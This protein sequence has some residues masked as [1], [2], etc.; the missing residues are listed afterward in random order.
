M[1]TTRATAKPAGKLPPIIQRR[2]HSLAAR[3]LH[4]SWLEGALWLVAAGCA[5]VLVQAT[6]DWLLDLSRGT[7]ALL[8]LGDLAIFGWF[9]FHYGIQ[10]WRKRLTPE[11]AAL[12][13]EKHWPALRTSLISAVQLARRP[14]GSPFLVDTLISQV[15][16][17][18]E[19]LDFRVVVGTGHLRKLL[20]AAVALLLVT[21]ALAW[22]EGPKSAILWQRLWLKNVPLPTQTIV[23][24]VSGNF[25]IQPGQTIELAANVQG[26]VPRSGRVEITYAGQPVQT[27]GITAKPG[28]PDLFTLMLPNV[29]QPL[30]YRFY[31]NDGRSPEFKVAIVHGPVLE[32]VT[33]EQLY[34]AYTALAKTQHAAGNLTLLA[35]S[36][37][38]VEGRA[39]QPLK[40]ARLQLSGL[41]QSVEM[42]VGADRKTV[43]AE[44][45]I[46]AEKLEGFS[47]VLQNTDGT[48]SQENTVYRVEI[49]PDKPPEITFAADQPELASFITTAHPR[50]RFEVRDD[51]QVKQVFLCCG[52]EGEKPDSPMLSKLK[53]IPLEV[54]KPAGALTYDYLWEKATDSGL[55][56]ESATINYWI[57]AIDNN[58]VTGPGI[59]RTPVHQWQVISIEAKRQELAEKLRKHGEAIDELSKRQEELRGNVGDLIKQD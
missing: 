48:E 1:K 38:H 43:S 37:L 27:I 3:V 17:R 2:L 40:A 49:I 10:P 24:P 12:R 11:L 16:K 51:F 59:G 7:R 42:K 32:A 29:Q 57:E 14:D 31:L 26:V 35:G 30:M 5:L 23:I 33:F 46:P 53:R 55:W 19:Q 41:E 36:K 8:L 22:W 21:G 58:D 6:A 34:P 45:A 13:A 15:A 9:I 28:N 47:I 18:V 44:L 25:A 56:K 52:S 54:P 39:N 50:L 4:I 20:A